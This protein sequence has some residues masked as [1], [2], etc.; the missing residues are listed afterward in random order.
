MDSK[1][2]FNSIARYILGEGTPPE[3]LSQSYAEALVSL[4]CDLNA[5]ETKVWS[6][7]LKSNFVFGLYDS[8]LSWLQP[9][10]NIRKRIFI[11]LAILESNKYYYGYFLNERPLN[12]DF[13]KLMYRIPYALIQAFFGAL[14]VRFRL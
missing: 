1:A 12:K 8:G 11:G 6:K 3:E 7:M 4:N 9:E 14:L 13:L 2:E 5:H 10:S